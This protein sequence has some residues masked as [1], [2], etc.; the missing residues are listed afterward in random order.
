MEALG[1]TLCQFQ[2]LVSKVQ[3]AMCNGMWPNIMDEVLDDYVEDRETR[4][5]APNNKPY[6]THMQTQMKVK[7]LYCPLHLQWQ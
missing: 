1:V 5:P 2:R 4:W 6:A 3:F 7:Y